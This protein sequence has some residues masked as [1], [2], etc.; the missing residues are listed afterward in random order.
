MNEY[1]PR[2]LG[3]DHISR[4]EVIERNRTLPN[5]I[6]GN[7]KRTNECDIKEESEF[8]ELD[9]KKR[10][11]KRIIRVNIQRNELVPLWPDGKAIAQPKLDDFKSI[12]ELIPADCR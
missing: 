5:Y 6:F 10:A 1:L 11:G 4:H 12:F 3:F 2:H 9:I 8:E 7:E